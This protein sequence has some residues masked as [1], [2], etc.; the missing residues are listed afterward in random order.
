MKLLSQF[1]SL[2]V[3]AEHD[4]K[5]LKKDNMGALFDNNPKAFKKMNADEREKKS[6][7]GPKFSAETIKIVRD[8]QDRSFPHLGR[9]QFAMWLSTEIEKG[10]ATLRDIDNE[11]ISIVDWLNVVGIGRLDGL[12]FENAVDRAYRWHYE[13]E[14][15][16][17]DEL[18]IK[19]KEEDVVYGWPDGYAIVR[20]PPKDLRDEGEAMGHC[21]AGYEPIVSAGSAIIF[22]LRDPKGRPHVTIEVA[23]NNNKV[24]QIKGKGNKPP[25]KQLYSSYVKEWLKTTK[26]DYETCDDYTLLLD[27][28]EA[29][30]LLTTTTKP[31]AMNFT[32][33]VIE[34][35]TDDDL[36]Q[37]V[38]NVKTLLTFDFYDNP[39][40]SRLEYIMASSNDVTQRLQA[41]KCTA[42]GNIETKFMLAS[43]VSPD[44]RLAFVKAMKQ[45]VE[46]GTHKSLVPA[47]IKLC[48][49]D[50]A[51]VAAAAQPTID[52][53][54][55]KKMP[56]SGYQIKAAEAAREDLQEISTNNPYYILHLSS[57]YNNTVGATKLYPI[58]AVSNS[59]TSKTMFNN[60]FYIRYND[61]V[62]KVGYHLAFSEIP[63]NSYLHKVITAIRSGKI[64][65]I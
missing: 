46:A 3:E 24:V 2:I 10:S 42:T 53:N 11:L 55:L 14:Q 36:K 32:E 30:K 1:I 19:H 44:V 51:A 64:P 33:E 58:I 17:N 8:L 40:F 16:Q 41:A 18:S 43:D 50:N 39:L 59:A 15:K 35:I 65:I 60:Y 45:Y 37:Y 54:A 34:Q 4:I 12:S 63:E 27:V 49:D 38:K 28:D 13:Q 47:F 7:E 23:A 9:K 21:V 56:N 61:D 22:S 48:N 20:V 29:R 26:F 25:S 57:Y 62:A 31:F 6:L 52:K 5:Q